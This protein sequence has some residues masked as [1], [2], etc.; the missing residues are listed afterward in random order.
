MVDL[1]QL[2]KV[3]LPPPRQQQ[4]VDRVY[5][6][7]RLHIGGDFHGQIEVPPLSRVRDEEIIF[8]QFHHIT[9]VT[10]KATPEK[11]IGWAH[12]VLIQLFKYVGT[13]I[14]IDGT[15]RCVPSHFRR[16]VMVM[17][18]DR[19]TGLFVP[20]FYMICTSQT[21]N[22]YYDVIHCIIQFTDQNIEPAH[23]VCDYDADLINAV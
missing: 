7:R 20:V 5:R 15:F 19:G 16:C 13:T 4:V 8:F 10:W 14:F 6:A 2:S 1:R 21:C 11:C 23:V 22:M 9:S 18:H 3:C 12:P 17:V